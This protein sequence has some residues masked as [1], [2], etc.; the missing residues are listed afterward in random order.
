MVRQEVAPSGQLARSLSACD[1]WMVIER[2]RRSV[3]LAWP[4]VG[5]GFDAG[6]MQLIEGFDTGFHH[7]L[8][9]NQ[10]GIGQ[11]G[12][13]RVGETDSYQGFRIAFDSPQYDI[14]IG[15][16][17]NLIKHGLLAH[18][19]DRRPIVTIRTQNTNS[20]EQSR[21]KRRRAMPAPPQRL[22]LL[23]PLAY[24]SHLFMTATRYESYLPI[25]ST[26]R[27]FWY[28][29]RQPDGLPSTSVCT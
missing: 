10:A 15:C 2:L 11:I 23:Q 19:S 13:R 29:A 3:Q 26:Q 20:G 18:N 24:D 16:F 27:P 6:L 7:R 14:A 25:L 12:T 4:R 5:L 1:D 22:F 17:E 9:H 8:G 28:V 21:T